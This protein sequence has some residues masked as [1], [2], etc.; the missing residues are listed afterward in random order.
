MSNSDPEH[1]WKCLAHIQSTHP[2]PFNTYAIE[3]GNSYRKRLLTKFGLVAASKSPY[4]QLLN[5]T[6]PAE[7]EQFCSE[8]SVGQSNSGGGSG[9]GYDDNNN[10]TSMSQIVS[11]LE[12]A[13]IINT[14]RP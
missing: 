1:I 7:M 10:R 14:K 13:T 9:T 6:S 11:F 4:L 5:F 12:S 2:S 8:Y 3:V